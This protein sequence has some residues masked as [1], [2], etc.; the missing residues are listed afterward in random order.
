M[1]KYLFI[2]GRNVELSLA[3]LKSVLGKFEFEKEKNAILVELENFDKSLLD[4]L[5]GVIA[6]G[7]VICKVDELEEKQIYLGIKNNFTYCIW[8]FSKATNLVSEILKKKFKEEKLKASQKNIYEEMELQGGGKANVLNSKRKIDEEYFVFRDFFGKVTKTTN[9]KLIEERDM[10]KPHRREELSISP[11]LAKIM[12]NLSG[13]KKGETLLDGFCGVGV[14]LQEA[15]LQKINVIGIDKDKNAIEEA[16]ENLEWFKFNK[17]NY[18]L[19]SNDS[20]KIK[21]REV[22]AMASEPDF[23]KILKK[24]PT[25][26][27]AK[28]TIKDFEDLMI[29][30][31]N[32]LKK[33][34]K[35]RIVITAPK[36]KTM[37]DR[38]SCDFE[39][40]LTKTGYK[41]AMDFPIPD[42]RKNQIVG[43]DLIVLI[44][45]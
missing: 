41:I 35:G 37:K 1:S 28:K 4:R 9:Y 33:E 27:Y 19:I 25:V 29:K 30:V 3:E 44:K 11:R 8:D 10:K 7:E 40:I 26:E 5:G 13:I 34:I 6:I 23:G 32:N 18:K 24:V 12:I 39:K 20:S 31:I 15:L 36:I 16:R 14:I 22:H 42:F 43:R 21:I 2:L 45:N 17:K 38:E